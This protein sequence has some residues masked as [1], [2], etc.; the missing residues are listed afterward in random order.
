MTCK[1]LLKINYEFYMCLFN[2]TC[3][4]VFQRTDLSSEDTW[5][6]WHGCLLCSAFRVAIPLAQA[7][8]YSLTFFP[9]STLW[10]GVGGLWVTHDSGLDGLY[11]SSLWLSPLLQDGHLTWVRPK[12]APLET[13]LGKMKTKVLSFHQGGWAARLW[14]G[15]AS[16]IFL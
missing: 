12:K 6:S 16:A 7:A 1:Y 5:P 10:V 13:C 8:S 9:H 2:E 11:T 15:A 14:H 3:R 4:G